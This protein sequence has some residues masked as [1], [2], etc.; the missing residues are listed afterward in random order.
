MPKAAF[1]PKTPDP[2]LSFLS[3]GV[4]IPILYHKREKLQASNVAILPEQ[5]HDVPERGYRN[6]GVDL[7]K[8]RFHAQGI[9][10]DL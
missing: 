1:S 2:F 3:S 9:R 4:L 7:L 5:F 10:I 6:S 8:R